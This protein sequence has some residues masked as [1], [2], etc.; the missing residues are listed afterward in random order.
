MFRAE[1]VQDADTILADTE[2]LI[3]TYHDPLTGSHGADRHA[4]RPAARWRHP[5]YSRPPPSSPSGTTCRLT[6]HLSQF[7]GEESWSLERF[8]L[9]P[10]DWFES[11]RLGDIARVGRALHLRQRRRDRAARSVGHRR[12]PLSDDLRLIAEGVAPVQAMRR[13]GVHVG[14]S[15]DGGGSEHGSMWLEAHTAL[16]LGRLRSGPT[17]MTAR[18]VLEMATLGSARMPRA[19]RRQWL[20]RGGLMWRRSRLA[21][22]GCP[23]C[24]SLDGSCG[25][26]APLWA[27]S[28]Q[29][30]RRRREARR[31]KRRT[32]VA[33]RRRDVEASRR[34]FSRMAGFARMSTAAGPAERSARSRRPLRVIGLAARGLVR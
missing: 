7:P 24:R 25:G 16:L 5:G 29:A 13:N 20:P 22:R 27:S 26:L 33:R 6:T 32:D 15:C 31:P 8:G 19:P 11:R 18:D 1:L 4:V 23:V 2:R 34:D 10:V 28:Q 17:G 3:K 30:H 14:L 9:R 21:A 12:R